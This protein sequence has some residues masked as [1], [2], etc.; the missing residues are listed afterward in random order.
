MSFYMANA[1][2]IRI[3]PE[4]QEDF[5]YLFN[6]KY[7]QIQNPIL[8]EFA[9]DY[10][11]NTEANGYHSVKLKNWSHHDYI[12]EW[13]GK[14][15]TKYENGFFTFSYYYNAN[16]FLNDF[17]NDF[18]KIILPLITEKIIEQDGW[19]EPLD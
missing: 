1:Q 9:D 11:I 19:C 17:Y 2:K 10:F 12:N 13:K 15:Q 6:E 5:G 18:E 7:E 3:K 16:G 14:Y 4:L 8:K